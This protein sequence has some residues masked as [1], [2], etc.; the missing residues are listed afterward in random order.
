MSIKTNNIKLI[1]IGFVI[2]AMI[3]PISGFAFLPVIDPTAVYN[4]IRQL[5]T[6]HNEYTEMQKQYANSQ[7]QLYQAKVITSNQEGHY[8]YG[9]LLDGGQY[10]TNR[11]WSPNNWQDALKGLA[12]GNPARY[13]QLVSQY[14]SDNPTMSQSD[15]SQ[16]AGHYNAIVYQDQIQNNQAASVTAT[17]AFNNIAEHLQHIRA[18]SKQIESAPNQKSATDLNT[19]MEGEIAYV[20]VEMLK[21]M[22][23]MNEQKADQNANKIRYETQTAQFNRLPDSQ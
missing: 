2:A 9:D 15:Y 21:Q 6:L 1:K 4:L 12:G 10:S 14:K 8:G 11:Q 19:R 23:L 20:Q 3:M 7:D 18:I 5:N 13:Q 17:Y 22:A 16:G